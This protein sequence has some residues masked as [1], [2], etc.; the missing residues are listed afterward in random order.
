MSSVGKAFSMFM[1]PFKTFF[2]SVAALSSLIAPESVDK[3]KP[4]GSLHFS[5]APLQDSLLSGVPVVVRSNETACVASARSGTIFDVEW[6]ADSGAS[7]S[8]ASVRSLIDQGIPES[9]IQQHVDKLQKSGSKLVMEPL[10]ARR[11]LVFMAVALE[12]LNIASL[13]IVPSHE[14][15]VKLSAVVDRSSG[16]RMSSRSLVKV[17]KR[18]KLRVLA[19]G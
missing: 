17:L 16:S 8:L 12:L 19:K 10:I 6:I 7:R 9:L 11:A 2:A 3:A 5:A 4:R 14:V 1:Y 18:F 15:W 13:T